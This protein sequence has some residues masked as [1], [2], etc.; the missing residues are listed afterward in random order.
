MATS[1]FRMP[2]LGADMEAGRL[3]VWKVDAGDA[4]SRGDVVATVETDKGA[5]DIEIWEDG[6]IDELLVAPD[7]KVPVG[8]V[9][10][11]IR[12][13]ATPGSPEAAPP[14]LAEPPFPVEPAGPVAPPSRSSALAS[15]PPRPSD[16]KRPPS[17]PSARRLARELGVDLAQV[18]GTGPHG[19]IK[20]ADV[21]GAATSPTPS[22]PAPRAARATARADTRSAAA[23]MRRAIAAAMT[24]SKREVPHYYLHH[25]VV[26]DAALD[27][28]AEVNAGRP[29]AQ[30]L[31]LAAL[32]VRATAVAAS[33]H[34]GLNGFW[35]EDGFDAAHRVHVGFAI[36]LRTGGL[37]APALHDADR[38]SLDGL[39]GG[40]RD[41]VRRARA[42]GLRARELTDPTLTVSSLG[43]RGVDGLYGV[44]HPPQTALVGFGTPRERAWAVDGLLGVRRVLRVTLAGDH[45]ASDG[46]VGALF[47]R[48]IDELL[49]APATLAAPGGSP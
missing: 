20:R 4:V 23:A 27:W 30:R 33:E 13:S 16:R 47:L 22:A 7:A 43:D 15:P 28:L 36:A 34:P 44:I 5:I 29:P 48:R 31:V 6:V 45:R 38:G 26:V 8:T 37:V 10:A 21:A 2:S 42:G 3:V 17:S 9:L 46:H 49:Q 40:I 35:T 14:P 41:L 32:L 12:E 39:M 18:V 24:R 11:R 1:E 19:A 25:D